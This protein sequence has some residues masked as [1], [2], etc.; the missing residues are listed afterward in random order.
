MNTVASLMSF[1]AVLELQYSI[2]VEDINTGTLASIVNKLC[3]CMF[4]Y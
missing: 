3:Y 1:R 2:I 4:A